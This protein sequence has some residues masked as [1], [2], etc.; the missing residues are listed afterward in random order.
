MEARNGENGSRGEAVSDA[1]ADS[2]GAFPCAGK[3]DGR[4]VAVDGSS[5]FATR[6]QRSASHGDGQREGGG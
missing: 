1:V 6:K 2:K 4:P 5:G 3:A